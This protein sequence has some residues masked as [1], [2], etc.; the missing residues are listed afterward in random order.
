[1]SMYVSHAI[2]HHC[3]YK[4]ESLQRRQ[5]AC[6]IPTA[7][8]KNTWVL[9]RPETHTYTCTCCKYK[10]TTVGPAQKAPVPFSLHSVALTPQ[11]VMSGMEIGAS[12][13]DSL[14]LMEGWGYSYH[15]SQCLAM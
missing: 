7:K 9:I 3:M 6:R 12:H 2:K 13:H 11:T 14:C 4:W 5:T 15:S 10:P 1:M 8:W